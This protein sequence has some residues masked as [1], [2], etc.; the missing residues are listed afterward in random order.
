[1][2]VACYLVVL[3]L[4]LKWGGGGVGV[5]GGLCVCGCVC[6]G[7]GSDSRYICRLIVTLMGRWLNV[8]K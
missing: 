1:M 6:V 2:V 5:V 3:F 7:G 4:T 8:L